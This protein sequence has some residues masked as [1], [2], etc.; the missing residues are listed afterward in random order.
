MDP[1]DMSTLICSTRNV[2]TVWTGVH[3]PSGYVHPD[4]LNEGR[5]Q[6]VIW[7]TWTNWTRPPHFCQ[8][9]LLRLM[10]KNESTI[11]TAQ[12]APKRTILK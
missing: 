10:Q 7:R 2:I 8:G 6:R 11:N 1:V 5:R 4:L 3:G 12:N 9:V